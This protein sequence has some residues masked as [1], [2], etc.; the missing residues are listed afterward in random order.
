MLYGYGHDGKDKFE[1]FL[2]I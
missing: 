1:N 2:A